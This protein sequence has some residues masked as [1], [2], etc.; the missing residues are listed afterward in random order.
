VFYNL[1]FRVKIVFIPIYPLADEVIPQQSTIEVEGQGP[2][3]ESARFPAAERRWVLL[4]FCDLGFRVKIVFRPIYHLADE[5][6]P[7][8]STIEVE[9]QGPESE[10]ARFPAAERRWCTSA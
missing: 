9:G 2:E 3:S 1:E 7:Q 5:V 6:I 8:Q 4:V 10:S